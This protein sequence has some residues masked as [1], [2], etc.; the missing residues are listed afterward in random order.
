MPI[1]KELS[2]KN[3][4]PLATTIN[5]KIDQPFSCPIEKLTLEKDAS[6]V[7]KIDFDP[8]MKQDR[9]SDHINGKLT[10]SHDGHPHK[11]IV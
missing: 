8:G 3:M 10:I 1:T 11:D 2:I 4:G 9:L 5:L 6:D 7:I